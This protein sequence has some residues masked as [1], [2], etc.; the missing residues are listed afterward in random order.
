MPSR[1]LTDLPGRSAQASPGGIRAQA[2]SAL[3]ALL[4]F[5]QSRLGQPRPS[6]SSSFPSRLSRADS[7]PLRSC[8]LKRE[9]I[10]FGGGTSELGRSIGTL[11]IESD[12]AGFRLRFGH[13]FTDCFEDYAK[14]GIVFLL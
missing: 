4:E 9:G 14:L 12:A 2:C 1:F 5:P 6:V 11:G 3:C 7:S 10:P 13:E 8:S